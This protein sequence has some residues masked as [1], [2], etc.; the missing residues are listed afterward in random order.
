MPISDWH[1]PNVTYDVRSRGELDIGW[2][3]AAL[4]NMAG[5]HLPSPVRARPVCSVGASD[6]FH[7]GGMFQ[8][9]VLDGGVEVV[10]MRVI[11]DAHSGGSGHWLQFMMFEEY[12]GWVCIHVVEHITCRGLCG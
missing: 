4:G 5:C 1:L 7:A 12:C 9:V 10:F 8:H 2:S 11:E 3:P 6:G